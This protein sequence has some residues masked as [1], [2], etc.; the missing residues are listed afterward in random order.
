[1]GNK[2]GVI[3][4]TYCNQASGYLPYLT[5]EVRNIKSELDRQEVTAY[6]DVQNEPISSVDH[7]RDSIS[8]YKNELVV[9][10]LQRPCRAG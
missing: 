8:R 3:L 7:L 10:F 2:K 5:D 4:L 1:M 9:F 6:F